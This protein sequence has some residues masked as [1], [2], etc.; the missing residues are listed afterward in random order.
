MTPPVTP[1][2]PELVDADAPPP[3]VQPRV[4]PIIL[5]RVANPR[6]W[7]EIGNLSLEDLRRRERRW[8]KDPCTRNLPFPANMFLGVKNQN[9]MGGSVRSVW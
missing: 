4:A 9:G 1:P 3:V 7:Y 5:R 6:A 2:V 8:A